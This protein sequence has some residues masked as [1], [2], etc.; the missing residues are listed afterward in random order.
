MFR[1]WVSLVAFY[2]AV[3]TGGEV[4]G[5][6]VT[7]HGVMIAVV[8]ALFFLL[9]SLGRRIGQRYF[10]EYHSAVPAGLRD[11]GFFGAVVAYFGLGFIAI[12]VY[13][14]AT[15]HLSIALLF[16]ILGLWLIASMFG[17]GSDE[18]NQREA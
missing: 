18:R 9:W 12:S 4:L 13:L 10:S 7:S 1:T 5:P 16:A 6:V 15:R 17:S 2:V 11:S 8:T 3:K 14:V